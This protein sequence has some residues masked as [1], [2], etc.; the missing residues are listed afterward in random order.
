LRR[1]PTPR[2]WL[3]ELREEKNMSV[4]ELAIAVDVTDIYIR[5]IENG[6]RSPST[7]LAI[8]IGE[9]LG[10]TEE[11]ALIKFFSLKH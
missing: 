9:V 7:Q 4:T 2:P 6:D 11:Q 5:Y 3:K 1:I 10:L 8:R